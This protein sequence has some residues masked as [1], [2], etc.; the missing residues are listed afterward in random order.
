MT[1]H[2][3]DEALGG[4]DHSAKMSDDALYEKIFGRS[5]E[6]KKKDAALAAEIEG[7]DPM[8]PANFAAADVVEIVLNAATKP[9]HSH[10][11][12]VL[13][14]LVIKE[15]ATCEVGTVLATWALEATLRLQ[16]EKTSGGDKAMFKELQ[17]ASIQRLVGDDAQVFV[18]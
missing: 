4:F 17:T 15:A 2:T 5:E 1:R 3:V 8:D 12:A 7:F 6:D 11:L 16:N 10:R 13:L 9:S 14:G 18:G